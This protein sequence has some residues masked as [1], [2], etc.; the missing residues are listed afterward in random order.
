[1]FVGA[2]FVVFVMDLCVFVREP[3]CA[4][5]IGGVCG[6]LGADLSH[7]WRFRFHVLMVVG[8][9]LVVFVMDLCV[10]SR[11]AVC[12]CDRRVLTNSSR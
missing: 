6:I 12:Y 9:A 2:Q 7:I 1:M 3:P 5:V 8:A 10:C 4:I 11:T